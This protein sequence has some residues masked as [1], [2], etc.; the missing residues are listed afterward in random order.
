MGLEVAVFRFY[1]IFLKG[2]QNQ[3]HGLEFSQN[4]LHTEKKKRLKFQ[5]MTFK[6][7]YVDNKL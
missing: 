3:R 6:G 1:L 2:A 4:T 5:E 7:F